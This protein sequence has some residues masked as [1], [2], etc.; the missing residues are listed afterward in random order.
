MHTENF[1]LSQKCTYK[2]VH[3]CTYTNMPRDF[4]HA[5]T[6][7]SVQTCAIFHLDYHRSPQAG[8]PAIG[9]LSLHTATSEICKIPTWFCT[10]VPQ[11]ILPP[12]W[13]LQGK[14]P[15]LSLS[16]DWSVGRSLS[17]IPT[18]PPSP[19]DTVPRCVCLYL[20][21]SPFLI[22]ASLKCHLFWEA[23]LALPKLSTNVPSMC[24]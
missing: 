14:V 13:H 12:P 3:T 19:F 15:T 9:Q 7:A 22:F 21:P 23:S 11:V 4:L 20:E 17:H 16:P 1:T 8:I 24:F 6:P 18:T 10:S 5:H 2:R